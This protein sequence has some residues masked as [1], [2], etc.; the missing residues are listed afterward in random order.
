M[1]VHLISHKEF[2]P[3][4]RITVVLNLGTD[5]SDA[6]EIFCQ[7]VAYKNQL[8]DMSVTHQVWHSQKHDMDMGHR[9]L[10]GS[11]VYL[12][13]T[14]ERKASARSPSNSSRRDKY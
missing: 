13:P 1:Q 11:L 2:K 10:C 12:H 6:R 7:Y 8:Q 9:Q 3:I 5:R 4:L 14:R